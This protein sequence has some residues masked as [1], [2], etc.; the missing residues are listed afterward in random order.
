MAGKKKLKKKKPSSA[1]SAKK[2]T[3]PKPKET[4]FKPHIVQRIDP[5][6]SPI[7]PLFHAASSTATRLPFIHSTAATPTMRATP[8][9]ATNISSTSHVD[10]ATMPCIIREILY[11]PPC[12]NDEI[13][14]LLEVAL[15]YHNSS[16]Y[17][18]AIQTY[19]K[20]QQV[21][22][23]LVEIK[24]GG[25]MQV[26]QI[27]YF[28]M[29]IGGVYQSLA[30][31]EMA[32]AEF[33]EAM[34]YAESGLPVNHPDRA[35]TYSAI[36]SVYVHLNQISLA[37]DYYVKCLLLR[38]QVLGENHVDTAVAKNNLAVCWHLANRTNV[39][40]DLYNSALQVFKQVLG[41]NHP[42]TMLVQ[43][44]LS[45][46]KTKALQE[47]AY[48]NGLLILWHSFVFEI[49]KFEP[50]SIPLSGKKT[51]TKK[52]GKKKKKK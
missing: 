1:A 24:Q 31:D 26:F 18:L 14:K 30:S 36:A 12:P 16:L 20:A 43:R 5:V 42:R 6:A 46:A 40:I 44:N 27:I 23:D 10:V 25:T 52:K 2:P 8:T 38:T 47:Y 19:I 22:I 51:A 37:K 13:A 50:I 45:K 33:L 39:A 48:V 21:W 9:F 32:L 28:R 17:Q 3:T 4:P 41:L 34:R 29:A 11:A 49:P 35:I 15:T 7:T